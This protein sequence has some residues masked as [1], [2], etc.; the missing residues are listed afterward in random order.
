LR[1]HPYAPNANKE[2]GRLMTID[3]PNVVI[4]EASSLPLPALLRHMDA[5]VSIRSG[6][7]R[8]AFMFGLKP[9]FLSGVARELFPLLFE[10]DKAEIIDD[11][12]ALEE[13]LGGTARGQKIRVRQP[14][15]R[16]VLARLESVAAEYAALCG[17]HS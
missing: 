6:A 15:L 10:S 17:R 14:D 8:E 1:R 12:T 16:A 4:D 9:I 2:L 11:M 13:R 7:S 3:R 5:F